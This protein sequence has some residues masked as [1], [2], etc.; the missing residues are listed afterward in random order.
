[1]ATMANFEVVI[2]KRVSSSSNPEICMANGL[3]TTPQWTQTQ[4]L[5]RMW[6]IFWSEGFGPNHV[7]FQSR[8]ILENRAHVRKNL[9]LKA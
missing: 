5:A 9:N 3:K 7:K 4:F 2:L 8:A 1:M 6:V